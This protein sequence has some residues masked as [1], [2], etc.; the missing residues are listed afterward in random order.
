MFLH[1]GTH[2][3]YPRNTDLYITLPFLFLYFSDTYLTL[4]FLSWGWN[5]W[6]VEFE[7]F[8]RIIKRHQVRWLGLSL[9]NSFKFCSLSKKCWAFI[10]EWDNVCPNLKPSS[11]FPTLLRKTVCICVCGLIIYCFRD[12]LVTHLWTTFS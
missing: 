11:Y 7:D 4:I 12:T 10:G 3:S 6:L 1:L 8:P 9:K 2:K 5:Y